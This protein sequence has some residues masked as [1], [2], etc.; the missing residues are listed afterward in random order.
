M[1]PDPLHPPIPTLSDS[2]IFE[3]RRRLVAVV[4]GEPRSP[5]RF[6]RRSRL[7][8]ALAAVCALTV[9]GV[10]LAFHGALLNWDVHEHA[11]FDPAELRPAPASSFSTVTQGDDWALI[12]WKSERGICVDYVYVDHRVAAGYNLFSSCGSSVIGS[13]PDRVY[14]QPAP[15]SHIGVML[16]Q[17][18]NPN[19]WIICGPVA[20]DVARVALR[21]RD[22]GLIPVQLFSAPAALDSP[23]RFYV[24]RDATGQLGAQTR[25][26]ELSVV[27]VIAYDA[28]GKVLQVEPVG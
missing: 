18:A 12:A 8:V 16:G 3:Y 25:R 15:T 11:Q 19:Q 10:A 2:A 22:G 23:L 1:T 6:V 5:R 27:D 28:H 26:A 21:S 9:G 13:P 20:S 24:Y 17:A 4:D 7:V 14:T